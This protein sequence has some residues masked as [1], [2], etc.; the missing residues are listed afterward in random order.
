MGIAFNC[1]GDF[2]FGKQI[3][4]M[5]VNGYDFRQFIAAGI[6]MTIMILSK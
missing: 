1:V 6:A 4:W 5:H 3:G 2:D